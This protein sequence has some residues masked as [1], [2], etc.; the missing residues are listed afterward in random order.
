MKLP[1]LK[2]CKACREYKIKDKYFRIL[3]ARGYTSKTCRDCE[4]FLGTNKP[5]FKI[6]KS[7]SVN[8]KSQRRCKICDKIKGKKAFRIIFAPTNSISLTCR[9]C[10]HLTGLYREDDN[11][12]SSGFMYILFDSSF[13]ALIKIGCTTDPEV[14]LFYYNKDK[15]IETCS[16]VYMSKLFLNVFD[17]EKHILNNIQVYAQPV[18][19]KREWF[20]A[21][22]RNKLIEEIKAFEVIGN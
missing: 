3:N 7:K 5:D 8:K 11:R 19:G 16:F 9:K 20:P 17:V 18:P 14:R 12:S 10:E 22:H 6:V 2:Q 4:S 21:E 15:P 13:P 1:K